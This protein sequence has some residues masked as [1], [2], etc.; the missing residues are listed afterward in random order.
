MCVDVTPGLKGDFKV[1]VA[2]SVVLDKKADDTPFTRLV[3]DTSLC[4]EGMPKPYPKPEAAAKVTQAIERAGGLKAAEP[5]SAALLVHT[6]PL[7][8]AAA[9]V[10]VAAVGIGFLISM[11]G[12]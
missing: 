10:V 11:R 5:K 4:P 8:L 12:K 3:A 2:G 9:G 7:Y 6:R 1:T